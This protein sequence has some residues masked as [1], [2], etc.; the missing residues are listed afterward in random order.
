VDSK[1]ALSDADFGT[2]GRD[3]GRRR[4]LGERGERLVDS[5]TIDDDRLSGLPWMRFRNSGVDNARESRENLLTAVREGKALVVEGETIGLDED[6]DSAFMPVTCF[7][8]DAI[9][10]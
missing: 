4:D 2:P 6:L 7:V 10:R 3:N 9:A 5:G 1:R 8:K